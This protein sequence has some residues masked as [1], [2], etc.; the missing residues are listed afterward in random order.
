MLGLFNSAADYASQDE[1]E[2]ELE[3]QDWWVSDR[4]GSIDDP[5]VSFDLDEA[6]TPHPERLAGAIALI[7][8]AL[9]SHAC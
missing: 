3:E 9:G 8:G 4:E 6:S 7:A 5:L 2:L 1:P